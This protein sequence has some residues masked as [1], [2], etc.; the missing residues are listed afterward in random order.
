[1][2]KAVYLA[3]T[4]E[5]SDR[6]DEVAHQIEDRTDAEVIEY[7][8]DS[9][10]KKN[11]ERDDYF[12]SNQG[13]QKRYQNHLENI[14]ISDAL[15]QVYPKEGSM[16][17]NGANVE[18]G[19]ALAHDVPC[20][21]V[22]NIPR[23]TMYVEVNRMPTVDTL[24]AEIRNLDVDQDSGGYEVGDVC[25]VAADTVRYARDSHG[26]PY[27]NHNQIARLWTDFLDDSLCRDIRA[28]EAAL[29]MCL[30]KMSRMQAG[31]VLD[32]HL[33]DIA[34]YSEVAMRCAQQDDEVEVKWTHFEPFGTESR[35][36]EADD[37]E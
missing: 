30:V 37:D 2:T 20:F 16:C 10:F 28:H 32:D 3:S 13:V 36:W 7:W 35:P 22:G 12:Y 18:L 31:E 5:L 26:D 11:E 21:S 29:M 17:L 8:W 6:V 34:G 33:V 14:R 24:I 4:R 25:G 9:Q 23:S 19:W 27:K 15:I 1:M